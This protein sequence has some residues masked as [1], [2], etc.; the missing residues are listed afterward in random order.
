MKTRIISLMAAAL[1]FT[2]LSCEKTEEPQ[3]GGNTT[4]GNFEV[5][6]TTN[7]S[8]ATVVDLN[9]E[10][11]D[12]TAITFKWSTGS[13][14]GT[15]NAITYKFEIAP[16]DKEYSEGYSEDLGRSIYERSFTVS[17]LNTYLRTNLLS[18]DG[19][20]VTYKVRISAVVAGS[21]VDQSGEVKFTATTYEPV[22][23]ELYMIGDATTAGWT[24]TAAVAMEYA[25]D[26]VFTWSGLLNSGSVKF[27]S[28][29]KDYWPGYVAKGPVSAD[30]YVA[31]P[32]DG[33]KG[34]AL[35]YFEKE[36]PKEDNAD[37][38]FRLAKTSGYNVTVNL[39]DAENPTVDFEPYEITGPDMDVYLITMG[40]TN[41]YHLMTKDALN[42]SIYR[43]NGNLPAG[44]FIFGQ[45][46][47]SLTNLYTAVENYEFT[48]ET[49][50]GQEATPIQFVGSNPE[51]F[52]T[53]PQSFDGKFFK[54]S[55]NT[56]SDNGQMTAWQFEPYEK[57][58]MMGDATPASNGWDMGVVQGDSNCWLMPTAEDPYVYTWE[59]TLNSGEL[60]FSCDLQSDWA[61][62]W[63]RATEPDMAFTT[64]ADQPVLFNASTSSD[65]KWRVTGGSYKITIDLKAETITIE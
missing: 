55:I 26:G 2:L 40:E 60:K 11:P 14:F 48:F 24:A 3:G 5:T 17:S 50:T 20:E 64:G 30:D 37:L 16:E 21:D 23:H 47:N 15:G 54:I 10:N 25:G 6:A 44:N 36:P 4:G 57:L 49:S 22:V 28:T 61:G 19:V 65:Y 51:Y 35:Q 45:D 62:Y 31:V 27:L 8:D 32:A 63:V 13:N 59:G 18:M 1:C 46:E 56:D 42:P 7:T 9:D 41:E 43:Y 12:E 29:N 38:K 33:A 53:I 58:Y 34:L 52:W 39:S